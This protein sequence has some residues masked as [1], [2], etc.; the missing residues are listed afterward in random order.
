MRLSLTMA[1]GAW[2]IGAGDGVSYDIKKAPSRG[3]GRNTNQRMAGGQNG[4]AK[5]RCSEPRGE[6]GDLAAWERAPIPD[7]SFLRMRREL[8]R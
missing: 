5:Y 7:N 4:V 6:D 2:R 8:G 1:T 3:D